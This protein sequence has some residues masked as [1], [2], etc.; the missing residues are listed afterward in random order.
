MSEHGDDIKQLPVDKIPP[1]HQELTIV[2]SLFK[3]QKNIFDKIL[4]K[5]KDL[6]ILA[7]LF[8]L[9][10]LPLINDFINKYIP[11]TNKSFYILIGIKAFLF[12]FSY[13]IVKNIYLVRIKK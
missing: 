7:I 4:E 1:T 3:E 8:I 9:F 6:L 10:S 5:S 11:I 12:V 13:F 2:N